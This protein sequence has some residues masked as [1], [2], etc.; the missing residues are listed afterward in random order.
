MIDVML[1]DFHL[2]QISSY[3]TAH[4]DVEVFYALTSSTWGES[5]M[6]L[7]SGIDPWGLTMFNK[8]QIDRFLEEWDRLRQ[9]TADEELRRDMDDV[10]KLAEVTD[11]EVDH[12]L[13]FVGD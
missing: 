3:P 13:L 4:L 11:S 1:V 7:V 8:M 10:R 9:R 12:Y 5:Q 2:K 6:V